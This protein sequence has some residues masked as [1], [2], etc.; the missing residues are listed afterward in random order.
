M[1]VRGLVFFHAGEAMLLQEELFALKV[2]LCK[3]DETFELQADGA[4]IG[5]LDKR[6]AYLVQ[7]VHQDSVLIVH[8]FDSDDT[9]VTPL[10]K[11][12]NH[13]HNLGQV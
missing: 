2:H 4:A 1:F 13:L 9:I 3:F 10:Q 6:D 8:G 12:H 11:G 7:R 5:S